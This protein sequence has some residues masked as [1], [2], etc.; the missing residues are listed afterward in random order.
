MVNEPVRLE[1]KILQDALRSRQ[2]GTTFKNKTKQRK[3]EEAM[4]IEE[5]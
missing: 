4:N 5:T 2:V 1:I 3:N